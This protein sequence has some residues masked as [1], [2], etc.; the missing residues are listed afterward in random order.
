MW[1]SDDPGP[2]KPCVSVR[3]I[4]GNF[5]RLKKLFSGKFSVV[6]LF[7]AQTFS[8]NLVSFRRKILMSRPC[9]FQTTD[10]HGLNF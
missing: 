1:P 6:T 2:R 8:M 5:R 7:V 10:Q 9:L 3:V 4:G